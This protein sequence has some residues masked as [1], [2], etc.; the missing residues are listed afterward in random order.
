MADILIKNMEMPKQMESPITITIFKNGSVWMNDVTFGKGK[1]PNAKA[2]ALPEHGRLIDA[3]ELKQK[4][5][6]SS[7]EFFENVI[8]VYDID[9]AKTIVEASADELTE[10]QILELQESERDYCMRYEPTYNSEDG[11]M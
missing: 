7:K 9:H 6:H 10:K 5:K 3:D 1:L 8:S 11:S 4:K 2:V